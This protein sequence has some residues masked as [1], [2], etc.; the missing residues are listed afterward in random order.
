MES[1][2][3]S[4]LHCRGLLRER[5]PSPPL[6]MLVN[7]P[8]ND[9]VVGD[10][11]TAMGITTSGTCGPETTRGSIQLG[12]C[13]PEIKTK[14]LR[15]GAYSLEIK[16]VSTRSNACGPKIAATRGKSSTCIDTKECNLVR[17]KRASGR[18]SS[19]GTLM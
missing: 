15:S 19:A 13:G 1:T 4:P 12:A 14:S 10:P 9:L 6:Y 16:M 5:T 8:K 11:E 7:L 17:E 18:D 2:F 3:L